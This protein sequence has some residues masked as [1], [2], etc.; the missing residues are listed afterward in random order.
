M[1]ELLKNS[2]LFVLFSAII[3]SLLMCFWGNYMPIECQKNIL[4]KRSNYGY[5]NTRLQDVKNYKNI[6]ILF[7]GSSHTYRSFDT[8]IFTKFGLKT[9]NLGTSAQT[10]IQSQLLLKRYIP[11]LHPKIIIFDAYPIMFNIDGV[12]SALDI[13]A[14]DKNDFYSLIMA[15]KE[16]NII[17]YNTLLYSFY[18][19][20]MDKHFINYESGQ[21]LDDTFIEGGYVYKNLSFATRSKF[22]YQ[23]IEIEKK[24]IEAFEEN[25]NYCKK[26]NIKYITIQTPIAKNLYCTIINRKSYDK[27]ISQF[28]NYIN[29]NSIMNLN[30]SLDFYDSEHL[31]QNGVN[32][33]DVKIFEILKL[34]H[35]IK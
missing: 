6:D 25:I 29:F 32:K 30:D 21:F 1:K 24:Q 18:R 12:E 13:I 22:N 27:I 28:G 4:F 19:N 8:R 33:F 14:K 3:Y 16:N 26:L 35:F 10:P 7:I 34:K 11:I 9:F 2:A 15:I 17:V 23:S 5:S 31:N 20:V